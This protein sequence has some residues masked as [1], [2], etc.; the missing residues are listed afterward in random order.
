VRLSHLI[1]AG[2]AK[3]RT[4]VILLGF[5]S[6]AWFMQVPELWNACVLIGAGC[7]MM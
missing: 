3:F 2:V 6:S 1:V 7:I 5:T 4:E